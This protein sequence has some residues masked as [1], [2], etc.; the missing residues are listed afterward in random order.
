MDLRTTFMG[1]EL[2]NPIIVGACN[3]VTDLKNLKRLEEAGASAIVYKSLFEEQLH[4]ENLMMSEAMGEFDGRHSEVN[5]MFPGFDHAGPK[6]YLMNLKKA[7]SSLN[8]PLFASLNAVYE[9]SWIDYA[10]QIEA[11]GIDGIELNL[12]SMPSDMDA[13]ANFMIESQIK[14]VE[15]IRSAVKIPV[16]VKLSP[17]YSNPIALI[18]KMDHMGADAFVLFNRLFQPDIDLDKEELH[19][20]YNLSAEGDYRLAMRFAGLLHG[21]IKANICSSGGVFTGQDVAKMLLAGADS[22][23]VVSTLY[24]NGIGQI[25]VILDQLK[26]WM[27]SKGYKSINDFKGKLAKKNIKDSFAYNRAQYIDIIMNSDEI[28]NKYPMI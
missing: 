11:A 17:F 3:L 6:E 21:N 2:K 24:V 18:N 26:N 28:F 4:L 13:G 9:E 22:V 15:G 16:A 8:I 12:Y 14:I 19:F 7:K 25:S 20:P 10:K 23:Q 5:S 27:N 1:I